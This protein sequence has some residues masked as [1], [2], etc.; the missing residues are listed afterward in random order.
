MKRNILGLGALLAAVV[1]SSFSAKFNTI[2]YLDYNSGAQQTP[3]NYTTKFTEPARPEPDAILDWF[4]IE[5]VNGSL[6]AGEFAAAFAALDTNSDNSLDDQA[7]GTV[8]FTYNSTTG[9]HAEL[10]KK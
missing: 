10:E 2:I 6:D 7:E 8:T 4:S 3:S 5:S 1:L 9:L